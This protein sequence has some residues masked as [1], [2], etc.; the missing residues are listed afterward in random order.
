[1]K[2]TQ[3]C[4]KC[5]GK[6]IA[7]VDRLGIPEEIIPAMTLTEGGWVKQRVPHGK[8]ETWICLSCGYTELYASGLE[9]VQELAAKYPDQVRVLGDAPRGG[10][11][12]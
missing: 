2:A 8:F 10:P 6:S 11:F 7:V 12:R 5:S 1:M 3:T 9:G 4:P